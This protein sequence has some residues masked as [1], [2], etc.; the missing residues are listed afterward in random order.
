MLSGTILIFTGVRIRAT[1]RRRQSVQTR[2]HRGRGT[3]LQTPTP[4]DVD[5]HQSAD[6]PKVRRFNTDG[7][8]RTI[9]ILTFT[10]VAFFVFWSPYVVVLLA[11]CF[12]NSF[13]PPS[14][15]EFA[16]MWI[17]N[18]N[19]AIN[20]FIYSSTN[21]QFRRQCVL[22]ASRLCCSRLSCPSSSTFMINHCLSCR[23]HAGIDHCRN[24]CR[25]QNE[26]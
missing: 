12:V 22:L 17:A 6:S 11:Q 4:T 19:S 24:E 5:S 2:L 16:V 1:L 20:V 23:M 13:K 26:V 3:T 8:R 14:G 21:A 10:S 15:V 7:S 18:T 25:A 9:K